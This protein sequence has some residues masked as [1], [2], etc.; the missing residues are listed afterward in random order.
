ME[1]EQAGRVSRAVRIWH[2]HFRS[3]D[4]RL[5]CAEGAELW[6]EVGE[7]LRREK[8]FPPGWIVSETLARTGAFGI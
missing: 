8:P 3:H 6:A 7:N 4:C 1:W 5:S 2:A